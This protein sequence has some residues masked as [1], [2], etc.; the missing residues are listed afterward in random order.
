MATEKTVQISQP[1]GHRVPRQALRAGL[2]V[3]DEAPELPNT[4]WRP[5]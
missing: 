1:P 3:Y 4:A 5:F 2:G